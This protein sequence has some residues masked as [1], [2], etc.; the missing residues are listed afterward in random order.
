MWGTLGTR[1]KEMKRAAH[2]RGQ[3]EG[4]KRRKESE[5]RHNMHMRTLTGWVKMVMAS[6]EF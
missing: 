1:N 4:E 5:K 6:L 3:G 2:G